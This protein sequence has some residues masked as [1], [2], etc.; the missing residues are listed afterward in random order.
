MKRQNFDSSVLT[1]PCAEGTSCSQ[2]VLSRDT[3][4]KLSPFPSTVV[5]V[6][7]R[8]FS[9]RHLVSWCRRSADNGVGSQTMP[10]FYTLKP[11]FRCKDIH[12]NLI[13]SGEKSVPSLTPE[14]C[15]NKSAVAIGNYLLLI[16]LGTKF[17]VGRTSHFP[18]SERR[19]ERFQ[20]SQI[21]SG[22]IY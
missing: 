9:P 11:L 18:N 16:G 2:S 22:I 13:T 14:W 7:S 1:Q 4:S 15:L 21:F 10:Y 8:G 20:I 12:S 6:T 17:I 19:M 5:T 3:K